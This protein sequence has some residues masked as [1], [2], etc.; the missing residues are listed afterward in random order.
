MD[1]PGF[2]GLG[3]FIALVFASIFFGF[4]RIILLIVLIVIAI[5]F[6]GR[7]PRRPMKIY[8]VRE[9]ELRK[10]KG[11]YLGFTPSNTTNARFFVKAWLSTIAE[12][13]TTLKVIVSDQK[14]QNSVFHS[15]TNTNRAT[16][17]GWMNKNQ[18]PEK[19]RYG[20]ISSFSQKKAIR[21]GKQS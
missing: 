5:L 19:I 18:T 15:G 8:L 20:A 11:E 13:G 10:F 17:V 9:F 6:V 12:D 7:L 14:P 16:A 3:L 21:E 2:S 1:R 4:A